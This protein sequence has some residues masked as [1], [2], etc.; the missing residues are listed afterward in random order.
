VWKDCQGEARKKRK[1]KF[2]ELAFISQGVQSKIMSR[3]SVAHLVAVVIE[4]EGIR[5]SLKQNRN[6][7]N[8]E[9]T[10]RLDETA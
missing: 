1:E 7:E 9:K 5:A 4:F 2:L 10:S 8:R 6:N 3:I